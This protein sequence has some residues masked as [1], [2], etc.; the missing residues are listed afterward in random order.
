MKLF[1]KTL[2]MLCVMTI[3]FLSVF[4]IPASAADT[5]RNSGFLYKD[6]KQTKYMATAE[7]DC[8]DH[9][10]RDDA[11]LTLTCDVPVRMLLRVRINYTD[12]NGKVKEMVEEKHIVT[13]TKKATFMLE[14]NSNEANWARAKFV[15]NSEKYGYFEDL[16]TAKYSL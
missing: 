6:G 4:T 16:L 11:H 13:P 3:A 12:D 14:V 10:F 9:I 5:S 8:D 2:T 7:L 15:C 1:K